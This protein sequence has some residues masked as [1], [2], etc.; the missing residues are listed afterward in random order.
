[1]N[2]MHLPSDDDGHPDREKVIRATF[3]ELDDVHGE[4]A[5]P[6]SLIAVHKLSTPDPLYDLQLMRAVKIANEQTV[7]EL[8]P[9]PPGGLPVQKKRKPNVT[10]PDASMA[11]S[12][13]LENEEDEAMKFTQIAVATALVAG[14]ASCQPATSTT[15]NANANTAEH[16]TQTRKS[17]A[18]SLNASVA[19][20]ST[21]QAPAK[22]S[23]LGPGYKANDSFIEFRK[24]LFADGWQP[25]SN[26]DCHDLLGM[27][28]F[29]DV[30][31]ETFWA[32]GTGYYVLHYIKNG[33]PLS[34]TLYGEIEALKEPDKSGVIWVTG[35]EY[36][37]STNFIPEET[38]PTYNPAYRKDK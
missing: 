36:T 4:G 26:P 5:R 31:P 16:S 13:N 14:T 33:T 35:W 10:Q 32:S 3:T 30:M 17:S 25:V 34:V 23:V 6:S 2:V 29:C 9:L 20:S 24:K 11:A 1:M 15:A 19:P 21:S 22:A 28:K 8:G 37:T 7:R 12:K 38:D 18:S 27:N